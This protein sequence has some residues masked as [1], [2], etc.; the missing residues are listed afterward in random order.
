MDQQPGTKG[1]IHIITLV[2]TFLLLLM[3]AATLSQAAQSAQVVGT[4]Q[5]KV[6]QGY[7]SL[8]ATEAPL[9]QIFQEIGRQAKITFDSNIGPGE[10][11]TIRL[12][13]VPFEEGLKRLAKN[14]TVFYTQGPNDKTHRI[15]R[16][17]VLSEGKGVSGQVK[18]SSQPEK[19][20]EPAPQEAKVTKPPPEPFKF[21]FDPAKSAGKEKAENQPR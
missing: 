11:V 2:E 8:E 20:K 16:V 1:S 4:F 15:E 9:V 19:V 17:V 12:D 6:S 14:V 13:R 7:L 3:A 5:L 18:A 10:K 21:Q